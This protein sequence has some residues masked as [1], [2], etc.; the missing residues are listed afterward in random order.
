MTHLC[1]LCL[2]GLYLFVQANTIGDRFVLKGDGGPVTL[3]H[4]GKRNSHV[5]NLDP[6]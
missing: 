2:F 6:Q 1:L 3:E 5:F 4:L